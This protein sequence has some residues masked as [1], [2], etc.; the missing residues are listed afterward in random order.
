MDE[1][2]RI[3]FLLKRPPQKLKEKATLILTK[4]HEPRIRGRS[5]WNRERS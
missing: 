5:Y 4:G 1:E 3:I 2:Q